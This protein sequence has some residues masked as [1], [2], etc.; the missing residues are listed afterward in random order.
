AACRLHRSAQCTPVVMAAAELDLPDLM[1][2][3]TQAQVDTTQ[4]WIRICWNID[5]RNPRN[6]VD[7][8]LEIDAQR[9]LLPFAFW[10]LLRTDTQK[11]T[12]YVPR[13]EARAVG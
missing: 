6:R 1:A 7:L 12:E 8:R 13:V 2:A 3:R 9:L 4:A 11:A 5:I 10:P